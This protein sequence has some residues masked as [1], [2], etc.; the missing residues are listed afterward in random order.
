V[1]AVTRD[2]GNVAAGVPRAWLRTASRQS[3]WRAVGWA[4]LAMVAGFGVVTAGLALPGLRAMD[5]ALRDAADAHRP[6]WAAVLAA[7]VNRVGQ[8][9]ALTSICTVLAAV[10][11]V[12]HRTW[13]PFAPVIAAFVLTG[14]VIQPLKLF[15]DRAAPHAPLPDDVAVRLFGQP[16]GLS[17]P[18]GHAVNT[19]VWY[20]I[21]GLLLA[22][23]LGPTARRWLRLAPPVLV[24]VA[25]V[26]LGFHWLTDMLAG[27][28]IGVPLAHAMTRVPW[29]LPAAPGTHPSRETISVAGSAPTPDASWAMTRR[30]AAPDDPDRTFETSAQ[31]SGTGG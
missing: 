16:D 28:A 14:V 21:A 17:Y 31:R 25:G 23:W 5:L 26:Y 6:H 18:S 11:A 27:F 22:P 20:A 29:P 2:P 30:L 9:G 1:V 15:F 19:V 7:T 12:R 10:L 4:T 13:W 3:R 24:T 8:G